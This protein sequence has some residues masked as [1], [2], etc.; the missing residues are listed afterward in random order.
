VYTEAMFGWFSKKPQYSL[1]LAASDA[2]SA[3]PLVDAI[4]IE[5]RYQLGPFVCDTSPVSHQGAFSNAVD[6]V[7]ADGSLVLAARSGKVVDTVEQHTEY[8]P[9]ASFA[10]LL[11]YVTIDHEDGEFSQ[12]AHLAPGSVSARGLR[13]GSQVMRG[14]QIAE[15]GKTGWVEYG[16]VGDHLHFMVF[17]QTK[18]EP[19]FVTLPVNWQL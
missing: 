16:E 18:A 10:H 1:P 7:V 13:V 2:V 15:T 8:G 17:T 6:F 5:R 4:P 11:N 9:D 14:Q 3:G 12:Y 19:G